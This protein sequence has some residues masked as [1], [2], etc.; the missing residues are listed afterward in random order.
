MGQPG[1]PKPTISPAAVCGLCRSSPASSPGG[2]SWGCGCRL[3]FKPQI[4]GAG[5]RSRQ[6]RGWREGMQS[7]GPCSRGR[8]QQKA[9]VS[10][11][12]PLHPTTWLAA[13]EQ[14]LGT[15]GL[16]GVLPPPLPALQR[17]ERGAGK[18]RNPDHSRR[19]IPLSPSTRS[20]LL[21]PVPALEECQGEGT[22]H[23]PH[24]LLQS[25][26]QQGWRERRGMWLL[27]WCPFWGDSPHGAPIAAVGPGGCPWSVPAVRRPSSR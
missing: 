10:C 15:P 12:L 25:P 7:P 18:P 14:P 11:V 6:R 4:P 17:E 23:R 21:G 5:R 3:L 26:A 9:T 13:R 24:L 19:C 16:S 22:H 1:A 8:H 27:P 2:V 20:C